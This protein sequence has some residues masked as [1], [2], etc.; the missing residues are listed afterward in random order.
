MFN[1]NPFNIHRAKTEA[2]NEDPAHYAMI[3]KKDAEH[4]AKL[5]KKPMPNMYDKK[6]S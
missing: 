2:L 6:F 5:G 4:R 1:T 3:A